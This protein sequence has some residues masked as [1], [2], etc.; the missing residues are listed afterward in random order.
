[1]P[2]IELVVTDLDG[3]LWHTD[4]AFHPA[5]LAALED[6]QKTGIPLLIATGRRVTS[7]RE[8]LAR[9]G[10]TPPAVMLNGA[11]GLELANGRRFHWHPF[12]TDAARATLAAYRTHGQFDP[13]V[14]VDH[15][16]LDAFTSDHPGTA[17]G[18]IRALGPKLGRADLDEVVEQYQVL[19]FGV[20]GTDFDRCHRVAEAV[21][22]FATPRVDRS[23]DHGGA[24]MIVSPAGLSKWNGVLAWCERA[25]ID[26][27]RLLAIGDGPNDVELLT[28]AAVAVTLE[29]SHPDALAAA[30][31][32]V[33]PAQDGGWAG[34]LQLLS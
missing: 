15:P 26:S 17:D 29:G 23:L 28:G 7:T 21:Q 19:S 30:D 24:A 13:I 4:E 2:D 8:P 9:V 5:T 14:Y 18:H 1:M 12:T 16:D 11:I 20:I 33:P 34:I 32:V 3:T 10:L 25:G 6:L 31:H 22:D 27:T